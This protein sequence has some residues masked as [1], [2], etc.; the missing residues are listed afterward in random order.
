VKFV[1]KRHRP[2]C[3]G[4]WCFRANDF[5]LEAYREHGVEAVIW[6][7]WRLWDSCRYSFYFTPSMWLWE[8]YPES[9]GIGP[10]VE[11]DALAVVDGRLYLCE[12]KSSAG[13]DGKQVDQLCSAA[14]HIRPDVLMIACMDDLTSNMKAAQAE[15]QTR[16]GTGIAIELMEFRAGELEKH[17]VLPG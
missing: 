13:L 17:S 16:L 1:S 12:A 4:D 6:T 10:D 2:R 11:I 8:V 9:R 5:V 7:L 3:P 14:A 15:L